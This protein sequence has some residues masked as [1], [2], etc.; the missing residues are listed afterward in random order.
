MP[1]HAGTHP[2]ISEAVA[3]AIRKLRQEHPRWTFQLVHDNLH[4]LARKQAELG[5][6]PGYAT[7][8]RFMKHHGLLKARRPRRHEL[9]PGYT[10]LERRATV[11]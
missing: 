2:S 4:A 10:A 5:V 11:L 6:P 8:C 3:A 7:V 1:S 9:E